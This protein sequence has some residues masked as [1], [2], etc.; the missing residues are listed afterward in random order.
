[1]RDYIV[2]M[3]TGE[4]VMVHH[5]VKGMKWGVRNDRQAVSASGGGEFGEDLSEEDLQ[6]MLKNGDISEE[7]YSKMLDN[8]K[9]GISFRPWRDRQIE[10]EKRRKK[11]SE[12]LKDK[13][14]HFI[15]PVGRKNPEFHRERW[16]Y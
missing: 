16:L 15:S 1:M 2:T 4:K 7:Q 5:G 10:E 11:E 6:E 3:E 9:N 12:T 8:L 13:F 14:I